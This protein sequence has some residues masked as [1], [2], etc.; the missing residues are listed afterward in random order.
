MGEEDG[1]EEGIGVRVRR[2]VGKAEEEAERN[3][4]EI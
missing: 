3:W 4:R 1:E 2:I